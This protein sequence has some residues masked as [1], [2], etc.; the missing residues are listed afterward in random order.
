MV[1][2][3]VCSGSGEGGKSSF[4]LETGQ[5]GREKRY[6]RPR[7]A[8]HGRVGRYSTN[9]F[10]L[11]GR[12]RGRSA[13]RA[14]TPLGRGRPTPLRPDEPLASLDPIVS[15]QPRPIPSSVKFVKKGAA[16]PSPDATPVVD[17]ALPAAMS[18]GGNAAGLPAAAPVVTPFKPFVP[19]PDLPTQT[20]PASIRFDF[21]DGCRITFP[22]GRW[23][24]RLRDRVT[25]NVL[26][27]TDLG[28]GSVASAKKYYVPFEIEVHSGGKP[29]LRHTLDLRDR[30]VLVQFPVGTLGDLMG[31]FPYAV[32]FQEKHGCELTCSM[33]ALILPLFK[34]CYPSIRFVTPE[35]IVAEHFYA[36][37][38]IGLFFD[39][40]AHIHQPCDFRIVGLHHT[41]AYILGVDTD[42]TP[43]LL[44]YAGDDSRPI[45]EKYVCVASQASTQCKYWNNPSGWR[46][47]VAFLKAH[48]YRVICIDQRPIHG[49]GMVWNHLP[50][51][52]ED[53]TGDR[54]LTERARWLRHAEFFVGLSSGLSWLAWATGTPVIMISGFSHPSNEFPTPH[55]VINYHTCNSCWNDVRVR[56]DH[57]DFL[58]CPR[59]AGTD[60]QFEC[61][62]L[63]TS[64]QVKATIRGVPGFAALAGPVAGV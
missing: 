14:R 27:E 47:I 5:D 50:Y 41:A 13:R 30:P 55:R 42:E 59:H 23:H 16:L 6:F 29:V 21:N 52:V 32:K 38:R 24:V 49:H 45:P 57:Q 60:R 18:A 4:F 9:V 48:G 54:P 36:T 39:D 1:A 20:G 40:D 56:F 46:E 58:W 10:H 8:E 44:D 12:S 37:Y 25:G 63:I 53:Q 31:W 11:A 64:E 26:F 35:E 2:T 3:S 43:P 15:K 61:T 19:A 34:A 62:R 28:A 7:Q 17:A 33:S 51:G 22:E